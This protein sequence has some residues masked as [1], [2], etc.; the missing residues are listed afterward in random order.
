MGCGNN[1]EE[2]GPVGWRR[3]EKALLIVI[4]PFSSQ[5]A[6]LKEF[7]SLHGN[8]IVQ[9]WNTIV[10][11]AVIKGNTCNKTDISLFPSKS[12]QSA[13]GEYLLVFRVCCFKLAGSRTIMKDG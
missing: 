1:S 8:G 7:P 10:I 4:V 11:I 3:K 5:L 12:K 13:L 2:T 9:K 6:I